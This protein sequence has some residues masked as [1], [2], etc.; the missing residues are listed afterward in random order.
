MPQKPLLEI[1]LGE[2][3]TGFYAL[4]AREKREY[5]GKPFLIIEI[6]DSSGRL[7]GTYWGDD[8]EKI[9]ESI[10]DAEVV[11]LQATIG[12]YKNEK[13][14][15]INRIRAAKPDE[16][17]G[18]NFLPKGKI[19]KEKLAAG[20]RE[21]I[22][23]V[24]DPFLSKLLK[25]IFGAPAFFES[26]IIAPAGKLWHGAYIGGLAEHT[27]NVTRICELAAEMFELCRR[28][29]LI[30]AALLHDIGKVEEI[31][32]RAHYDYSIRGRLLGHIVI[33]ERIIVAAISKIEDFPKSLADELSHMILSH[34]GEP[35]MGSAIYPK[36]LEGAILHH[37][38]WLESQANAFSHVIEKELPDGG[39]F[40][41]WVRP[42]GRFLYLDG[43]RDEE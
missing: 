17:A 36:T 40:S 8:A 19:P 38:D 27:I 21:K 29:L 34:H 37:A 39:H 7:K 11:K 20:I 31:E 33:G 1:A 26:F 23:T 30:T 18:L 4:R 3:F 32:S 6:G 9:F 41:G 13:E 10:Q 15:K 12:E 2:A 42:V 14:V 43:Y 5:D 35:S 25:E 16:Y 24:A 22:A 28:D